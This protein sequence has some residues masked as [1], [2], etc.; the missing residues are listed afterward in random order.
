MQIEKTNTPSSINDPKKLNYS[1]QQTASAQQQA[2]QQINPSAAVSAHQLFN[3]NISNKNILSH[4]EFLQKQFESLHNL[5]YNNNENINKNNT[6]L[7]QNNNGNNNNMNLGNQ[8]QHQMKLNQQFNQFTNAYEFPLKNLINSNLYNTKLNNSLQQ[9]GG[10]MYNQDAAAAAG[11]Q[12]LNELL[13]K[14]NQAHLMSHLNG[15]TAN[16]N[17]RGNLSNGTGANNPNSMVRN[18]GAQNL[19]VPPPGFNVAGSTSNNY[20]TSSSSTTS[21]SS[22]AAS[23]VENSA[24]STPALNQNKIVTNSS[25]M[26]TGNYNLDFLM[27]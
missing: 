11:A 5:N 2:P 23:S 9:N 25:F 20:P 15:S 27:L 6:N 22:S 13:L 4:I 14:T 8:Q 26:P 1:S 7:I 19:I 12:S 16:M 24:S 18:G 17:A 3:S 10:S 21:S